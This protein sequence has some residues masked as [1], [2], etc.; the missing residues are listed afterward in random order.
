MRI[1]RFSRAARQVNGVDVGDV[2]EIGNRCIEGRPAFFDFGA[3]AA[4]FSASASTALP[5]KNCFSR[6]VIFHWLSVFLCSSSF[7]LNIYMTVALKN[8]R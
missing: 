2:Q 5:Y 6:H 8:F 7:L 3:Y 1:A 4:F